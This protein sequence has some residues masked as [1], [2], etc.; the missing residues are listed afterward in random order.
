MVDGSKH[1]KLNMGLARSI[2]VTW[3][4]LESV[5]ATKE[6]RIKYRGAHGTCGVI[7]GR[8][9]YGQQEKHG[10]WMPGERSVADLGCERG[11]EDVL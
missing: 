6:V 7:D 8:V 1:W 3:G 2:K 4:K 11:I 5:R 9:P 10:S